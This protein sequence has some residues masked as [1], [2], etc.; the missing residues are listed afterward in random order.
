[1]IPGRTYKPEE[2]LQA[3]WRRKWLILVPFVTL[4]T[5]TA[6]WTQSLPNRYRSETL[7]QI[8]PQRVP[9]SYVRSTVTSRIEDRLQA[10]RQQILNRTRLERLIAD[11]NLFE[12]ERRAGIMEDIVERMRQDIKIETVKGDAFRVSFDSADPQTAKKVTERLASMIVEENLRDRE[13][14]AEGANQFFDAQLEDA[15]RRLVD[16]EKKLEQYRRVHSGE[17]PSQLGSN[18]QVIQ[19]S[20][21]QLQA[22][23]DSINRDRDRRLVF[24]RELSDLT[25]AM[26]AAP[27]HSPGAPPVDSAAVA[28]AP[29]AV[30]LESARNALRMLEL[31]YKPTH[32]DVIAIKRAIRDLEAK[33]AKELA[34]GA[35]ADAGVS[36]VARAREQRMREV[37]AEI[38]NIDR[39]IAHKQGEQRRVQGVVA[40]YQARVDAAPTRESE[41]IALTR[42]YDTLQ[43]VYTS[44]LAKKEES[45]VAANLERRQIGEQFKVLD[46]ARLPERPFS[47]NRFKLFA[48][49]ALAGIVFGVGLGAL[50]EYRDSTLRNDDDVLVALQL[51]VVAMIPVVDEEDDEGRMRRR[52]AFA[53]LGVTLV[54]A[55]GAA[56]WK[57]AL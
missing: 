26:T 25:N 27:A 42:D 35:T 11:F 34:A 4:A 5:G 17:L 48:L 9:E 33:A 40:G 50:V 28:A 22:I 52:L 32:P 20:Q 57:V 54:L 24:E 1:M 13:A 16:H 18:L 37:R 12:G 53:A 3:A 55:A 10:L 36:P 6:V 45:K 14:I 56:L 21:T 8:I 49:G 41:M 38:E 51:P 31:R 47:P 30:Q 15:R 2:I 19:S 46:A 7:I 39:Q 29:A 44:L 43:K 23:N